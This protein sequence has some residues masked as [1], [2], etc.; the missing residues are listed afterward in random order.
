[1]RPTC[2]AV[3]L[4]YALLPRSSLLTAAAATLPPPHCHLTPLPQV[5]TCVHEALAE[6]PECGEVEV[7]VGHRAL[8]DL[9]LS[10]IGVSREAR[11]SVVQL[12]STAS[13]ASPLHAT[14]RSKRWPSIKAGLEG[15]GLS[16]DAVGRC[17]QL[18]LQAAGEGE[19]ALFRLRTMLAHTAANKQQQHGGGGG[20]SGHRAGS[21]PHPGASALS[22]L[23]EL[24][25]LLQV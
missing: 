3:H 24:Q 8:Y 6:L 9:A 15:I 2:L 22:C 12:L 23:D 5:I 10:F 13:A 18:V 19:P 16:A 17:R 7:R 1:M 11:G 14:A 20:G 21:R 4:G 25:Q